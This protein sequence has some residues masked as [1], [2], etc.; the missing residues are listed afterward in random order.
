MLKTI[1]AHEGYVLGV[2]FSP[3]GQTVASA[4]YDNTVKL[5]SREGVLLK[6]LLQGSS[7]SVTSVVFSP[8]GQLVASGSYDGYVRLWSRQNGTLLKTLRSEERV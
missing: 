3:D 6:T 2:S 8:D 7:D 4:G 1:F 5:W